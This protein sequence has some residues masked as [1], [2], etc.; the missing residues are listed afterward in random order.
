M[1]KL[2][3]ADT[4]RWALHALAYDLCEA[5]LRIE[6]ADDLRKVPQR[7][8]RE[9]IDIVL[10]GW[11][12]PGADAIAVLRALK[13]KSPQ[14]VRLLFGNPAE[15]AQAAASIK[16]LNVFRLVRKPWSTVTLL[17]AIRDANSYR[18][19][20]MAA[21]T[22]VM[23]MR[24]M[25]KSSEIRPVGTVDF[26]PD[27]TIVLDPDSLGEDLNDLDFGKSSH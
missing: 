12:A 10:L 26:G 3:I 4:D 19:M 22:A 11:H 17:N 8:Q 24:G 5:H 21:M 13:E 16:D 7:V 27:N 6:I 2:L 18:T 15:L 1:H 9:N 14:T 20:E 23:K 25:E